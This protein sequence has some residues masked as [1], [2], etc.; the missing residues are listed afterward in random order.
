[1]L[2]LSRDRKKKNYLDRQ[3]LIGA[4]YS[5]LMLVFP[6]C[7]P[8]IFLNFKVSE[9]FPSKFYIA[10]A[11]LE[12]LLSSILMVMKSF[13]LI[14][15]QKYRQM[16]YFLR[17]IVGLP[18]TIVL[19]SRISSDFSSLVRFV[20]GILFL[21]HTGLRSGIKF[22]SFYFTAGMLAYSFLDHYPLISK[23]HV[24]LVLAA[25][26]FSAVFSGIDSFYRAKIKKISRK[27]KS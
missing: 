19:G 21:R 24:Q 16:E 23:N 17:I 5:L 7:V 18:V 14:R 3:I 20:L 4:G 22:Y 11:S 12:F 25:V 8:L 2:A 15:L 13:S 9:G 27:R 26:L 10:G 1:M 6:F